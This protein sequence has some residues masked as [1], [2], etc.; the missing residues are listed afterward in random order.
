[1]PDLKDPQNEWDVKEVWDKQWIKD[2]IY[3][4]VKWAGWSFKYNFYKSANHLIGTSKII[5][6]YEHKLKYRWKKIKTA[7]KID[8]TNNNDRVVSS[9]DESASHKYI[10]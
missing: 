6:D 9:E 8:I 4:L 5:A 7:S 10:W 3:Y 2:I 1:M